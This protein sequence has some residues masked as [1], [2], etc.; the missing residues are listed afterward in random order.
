MTIL[1]TAK[2]R[3]IVCDSVVRSSQ[4]NY[5]FIHTDVLTRI[6]ID[7]IFGD[8][9]ELTELRAVEY[10]ELPTD[11]GTQEVTVTRVYHDFTELDTVKRSPLIDKPNELMI[12]LQRPV[13]DYD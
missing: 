2:G 13:P 4:F 10:L 8:P 7:E 6:E 1:T 11:E 5:L 12:F 3:D 9:E